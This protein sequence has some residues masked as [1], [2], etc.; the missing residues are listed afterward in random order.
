MGKHI[1]LRSEFELNSFE[2]L[3]SEFTKVK[4]L[5]AYHGKNRNGSNFSKEMLT[6]MAET[7]LKNVPIVGHWIEEEGNFGGHDGAWEE[8]GN[9]FR[10]KDLTRP[11]GVVPSDTELSWEVRRENDGYTE[12]EYLTCTGILWS[13]RYP[14]CEKIIRDGAGQSMEVNLRDY[15]FDEDD[16]LVPTDAEFSALCILGKDDD[17]DKT[18]EP[19]FEQASIDV[20]ALDGFKSAYFELLDELKKMAQENPESSES[21]SDP[22]PQDPSE[23]D[24]DPE[25]PEDPVDNPESEVPEEPVVNYEAMYH[26][27]CDQYR[28]VSEELAAVTTRIADLQASFDAYVASHS[29]DNAEYDELCSFRS[30]VE[31]E[32]HTAQIQ[33]VLAD[34][35]ETLSGNADYAALRD[36]AMSYENPDDLRRDCYVILGKSVKPNKAKNHETPVMRF[37][38][39][40]D[41]DPE[42]YG[43]LFLE[44]KK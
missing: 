10:Y 33:E 38:V 39:V 11:F 37:G 34:F 8:S 28:T 7:S 27:V 12:H 40:R 6:K 25:V 42:P 23:P 24:A 44:L 13:G 19:C 18:I 2:K 29:H 17:P 32:Q 21:E 4:I 30:N 31:N 3:N 5:V 15:T 41:N 26:E 43:G 22:V 35:D 1:A 20:Y 9:S 16:Y 14:E 36:T